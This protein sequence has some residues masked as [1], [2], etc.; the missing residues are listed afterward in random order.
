MFSWGIWWDTFLVCDQNWFLIIISDKLV[1]VS[2]V[3]F[4]DLTHE[5]PYCGLPLV[6]NKGHLA[7]KLLETMSKN[8]NLL[9]TF[10][11]VT[12]AS[13]AI[14]QHLQRQCLLLSL[15]T[16]NQ[17]NNHCYIYVYMLFSTPHPR[18]WLPCW[19]EQDLKYL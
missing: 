7:N 11:M 12:A 15:I 2:I 13:C 3:V 10:K 5:N 16:L 6:Q 14:R 19:I 8:S 18:R 17:R 9:A 4:N 1:W